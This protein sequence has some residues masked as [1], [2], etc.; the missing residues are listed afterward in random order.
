MITKRGAELIDEDRSS[1]YG[2]GAGAIGG[3]TAGGLIARA[4]NRRRANGSWEFV[5]KNPM[6]YVG[7]SPAM[8]AATRSR[9]FR[10]GGGLVGGL[11]GAALAA[12]ALGSSC[13][14]TQKTA[15]ELEGSNMLLAG[16]AGAGA[17]IGAHTALTAAMLPHLRKCV[18]GNDLTDRES[19]ELVKRM[20]SGQKVK[21]RID[22]SLAD[23]LTA[24]YN[25]M[26][27]TVQ[28]G[29]NSYTLAH[30]LGHATGPINKNRL[31]IKGI[32]FTHAP[33]LYALRPLAEGARSAQQAYNRAKGISEDK[34][35]KALAAATWGA[36][37]SSAGQLAEEAQASLRGMHAIGKIQGRQGVIRAAK[38]LGPA[39]GTYAAMAGLSH[40]LA[41][42]IG[43]RM[44]QHWAEKEMAE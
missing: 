5:E 23:P 36:R 41:P 28:A 33:W 18:S 10:L 12:K 4:I 26:T 35:S 38:S 42:Y 14:N 27:D 2:A 44:G 25:P 21:T 3:A 31:G 43:K 8:R 39:F 32:L 22:H 9:N 15:E 30:E 40:G 24:H 19:A 20:T 1:L 6:E 16:G 37:L 34:D 11:A 29:K 7:K 17:T 13:G